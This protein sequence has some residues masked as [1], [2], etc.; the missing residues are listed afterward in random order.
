M[1]ELAS[2]VGMHKT[3]YFKWERSVF[4]KNSGELAI[5]LIKYR[6]IFKVNYYS[7]K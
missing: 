1:L 3:S 2:T 6:L 5:L 4:G 7:G